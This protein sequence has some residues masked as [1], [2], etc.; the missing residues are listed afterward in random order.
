MRKHMMWRFW[1]WPRP[2][3]DYLTAMALL[4]RAVREREPDWSEIRIIRRVGH[5]DGGVVM[6]IHK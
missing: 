3:Y 6:Q 5:P 1:K 4:V 2:P